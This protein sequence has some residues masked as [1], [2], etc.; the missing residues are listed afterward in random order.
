MNENYYSK[1]SE[2][3]K[4]SDSIK[5]EKLSLYNTDFHKREFIEK[6]VND[7]NL[8]EKLSKEKLKII[9][10]YYLEEIKKKLDN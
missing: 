3:R 8:L 7:P 5:V 4:L 2:K 6:L 10:N 9:V 1:A